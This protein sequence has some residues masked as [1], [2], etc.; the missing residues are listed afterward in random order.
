MYVNITQLYINITQMYV[1]ITQLYI[2]ITQL[3]VNITQLY[4]NTTQLYI[5]MY[6]TKETN[7]S[8]MS[9]LNAQ[10]NPIYTFLELLGTQH[11][12]KV[13]RSTVKEQNF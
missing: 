9:V 4:F 3:Y 7:F 1:N 11:I 12:L 13:T 10:L 2:N 8:E 6:G 5:T